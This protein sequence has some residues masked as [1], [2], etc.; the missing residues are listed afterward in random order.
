MKTLVSSR[1][2]SGV[3]LSGEDGLGDGSGE[4]LDGSGD[5]GGDRGVAES[6]ER[7]R[8]RFDVRSVGVGWGIAERAL[9]RLS[10]RAWIDVALGVE[11]ELVEREISVSVLGG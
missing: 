5:R 11:V 4:V 1:R 2:E 10:R 8:S 9:S 7:G 3:A 6:V